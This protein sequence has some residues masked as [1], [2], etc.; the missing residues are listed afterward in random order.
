MSLDEERRGQFGH[1]QR[2]VTIDIGD[3]AY[4]TAEFTGE[5]GNVGGTV[6]YYVD[7]DA[8]CT[9]LVRACSCVLEHRQSVNNGSVLE[10]RRRLAPFN[11]AGTWY[12]QASLL[13]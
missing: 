12:F 1:R 4:D 8:N 6:T 3:L 13:G 7:T 11:A 9:T 2:C 5:T 10:L